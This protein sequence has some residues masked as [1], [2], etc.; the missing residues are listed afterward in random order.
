V[1]HFDLSRE[2]HLDLSR[3]SEYTTEQ[4]GLAQTRAYLDAMESRLGELAERPLM[5]HQRAELGHDIFSFP[6]ES[7]IIFYMQ[8]DFGISVVR[9]LHKRQD[10]LNHVE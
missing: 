9:I 2:A 4:W 3:F 5:G 1:A 7:H 10:P 6:F 8:T